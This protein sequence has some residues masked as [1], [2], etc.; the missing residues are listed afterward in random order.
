M[1]QELL[2]SSLSI[3]YWPL[4]TL[5]ISAGWVVVSIAKLKIHPFL[6]LMSAS[7]LVGLLTGTLPKIS[8]E[9]KGLFHDRVEI[10]MSET[11]S[12]NISKSVKW[13]LLGFGNTAGG[14]ALL[15]ALAAII[16]SCMMKSGAE[17]KLFVV[18]FLFLA[19]KCRICITSKWFYFIHSCFF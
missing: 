7:I 18:Y 3:E 6:A 10:P 9:N 15:I 4:W 2:A 11:D 19:K 13:S 1:N 8:S 17:R 14:I 5:I 12:L 16:G